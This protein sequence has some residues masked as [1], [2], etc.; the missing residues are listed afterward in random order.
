MVAKVAD[1]WALPELQLDTG[2]PWARPIPNLS[3]RLSKGAELGVQSR[4]A[5]SAW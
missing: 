5:G 2:K 3:I 4:G 1:P